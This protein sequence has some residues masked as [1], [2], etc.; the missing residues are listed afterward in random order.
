MEMN[1]ALKMLCEKYSVTAAVSIKDGE[2]IVDGKALPLLPWRAERRFVEFRNHVNG[3]YLKGISTMRV[4]HIAE[5]GADLFDILYREIDVCEW[6]LGAKVCEIFAI[7]SDKALNA[8]AKT[9]K[10]YICTLELA[11]TLAAGA[12]VIDKHEIIA[13]HGVICDRVVD[14]QVPQ[15]SIYV[16]GTDGKKNTYTDVDAELFGLS[17]DDCAKIRS[18]FAIAKDGLDYTAD[19]AHLAAVIAAAKRSLE[20]LEN[21]KL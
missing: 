18:A 15:S 21:V 13:E 19:A 10:G 12:E 1:Q 9:D 7:R 17:V 14:T 2:A 16:F 11:A 20:T 5:A 4:C 6:I 8:I 3:K